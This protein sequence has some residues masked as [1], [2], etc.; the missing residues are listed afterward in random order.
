MTDI[1]VPVAGI[2][3]DCDG[4]LV[5]SLEAAAVAW[6]AWS[7]RYAPGYDFRTQVEHG[8]RAADTV[9]TLVHPDNLAEAVAALEA[10]EVHG[11]GATVGIAGAVALTS[12]IPAARW[13]VV[14]SG[15]RVL[16]TARLAAAGH[17]TPGGLVTADDVQRGKPDPEPYLR[18]AAVLGIDPA[19]CAVFEDAAAGVLAARAA[20]AGYV[21]GVGDHLD[22]AIVDAW[23]PDLSAVR[24]A[25][26]ELMLRA[27]DAAR[28]R[29]GTRR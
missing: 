10:E 18:G 26:G 24:Y 3:F 5:D 11:A 25:D 1:R 7:A 27:Q 9:A 14:T 2:L 22:D 28:R 15:T 16:A 19:D 23:V 21:V 4:V 6:D 13:A 29:R 20:G 12:S 8:V 17:G